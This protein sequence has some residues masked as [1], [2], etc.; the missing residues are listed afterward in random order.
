MEK[1][2]LNN[3]RT[4]KSLRT[5]NIRVCHFFCKYGRIHSFKF[6][7]RIGIGYNKL[8]R[9]PKFPQS[10]SMVQKNMLNE[11]QII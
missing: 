11:P 1:K 10:S 9:E 7:G 3:G 6:S 4:L 5:K 8:L 2:D